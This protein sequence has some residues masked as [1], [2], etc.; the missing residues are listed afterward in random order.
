MSNGNNN[1]ALAGGFAGAGFLGGI[2]TSLLESNY[3]QQERDYQWKSAVNQVQRENAQ[4]LKQIGLA[5]RRTA[6]VYSYQADRFKQQLGLIKEEYNR[7]GEDLQRQLQGAFAQSAYARQAQLAQL[8]QVTG[9]NT[10]ATDGGNRSRQRADVLGTLATFGRNQAMEAERLA[11]VVGQTQRERG[12]LGRQVK[13]SVFNAYG[14]LGILPELQRYYGA[15][16]PDAP[17][18]MNSGMMIA[19]AGMAGFSGAL[20]GLGIGPT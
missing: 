4:Q 8:A 6:D 19:Q 2:T 9:Y 1:W 17:M 14:D 12:A 11:G 15:A 3:A 16:I 7:A 13:Q 20:S 10:A 18:R 5:N